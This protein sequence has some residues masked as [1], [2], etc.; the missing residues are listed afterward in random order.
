MRRIGVLRVSA[1]AVLLALVGG[2]G[3]GADTSKVGETIYNRSCFSCHASGVSGAPVPG[4]E[5][6]W[7]PRAAKG[8]D[9]LLQSVK[10]G[11]PPGMPPMGLCMS[12]TDDEL[13]AAIDFMLSQ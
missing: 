6:A 5:A 9:V 3:E 7:A 2:C 1:S 13:K 4:D 10:D 8:R 11:I 12:C